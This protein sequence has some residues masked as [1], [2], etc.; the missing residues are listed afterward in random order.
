MA[1]CI[2]VIDNKQREKDGGII[3]KLFDQMKQKKADVEQSKRDLYTKDNEF[4]RLKRE[5]VYNI[6]DF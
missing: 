6:G 1:D 2:E 4:N 5:I 3:Q